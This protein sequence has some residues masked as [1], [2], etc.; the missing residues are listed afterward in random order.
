M[1]QYQTGVC[2]ETHKNISFFDTIV[3]ESE[4]KTEGQASKPKKILL[5]L[6]KVN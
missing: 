5:K 3:D 6:N 4:R 1:V 2:K